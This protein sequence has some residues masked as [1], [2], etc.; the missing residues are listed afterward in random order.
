M[1]SFNARSLL[2][3]LCPSKRTEIG[4]NRFERHPIGVNEVTEGTV[5]SLRG[6]VEEVFGLSW[7][8]AAGIW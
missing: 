5:D 6:A 7:G 8:I 2:E 3:L 4:A 1:L